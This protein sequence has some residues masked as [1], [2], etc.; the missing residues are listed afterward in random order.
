VKIQTNLDQTK[1]KKKTKKRK[2]VKSY[3]KNFD[4]TK[5][6]VRQKIGTKKLVCSQKIYYKN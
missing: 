4:K 3:K 1:Q 2:L 5:K 6:F